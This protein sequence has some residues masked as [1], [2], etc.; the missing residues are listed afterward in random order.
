MIL[1]EEDRKALVNHR[2]LRAK[3]TME[4]VKAVM[5]LYSIT[6]HSHIGVMNQLGLHFISKGLVS[7][8][9]GKL[10]KHLFELRQSGDYDDWEV[11][12]EDKILPL[13]EPA[14]KFIQEIEILINNP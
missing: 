8:E 10:L 5:Q 13:V 6:T 1:R 2:L 11:I 7:N 12:E 3:E 9:L 4:E 14:Q